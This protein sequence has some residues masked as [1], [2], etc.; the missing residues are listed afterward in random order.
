MGGGSLVGVETVGRNV[1]WSGERRG[2]G[3]GGGTGRGS[4][5]EGA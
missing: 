2:D 4:A 1:G 5:G 3:R